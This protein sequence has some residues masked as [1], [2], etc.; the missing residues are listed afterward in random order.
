MKYFIICF[1]KNMCIVNW[2]LGCVYMHSHLSHRVQLVS[3]LSG[4]VA[5]MTGTII[6]LTSNVAMLLIWTWP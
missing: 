4:S 2:N 1:S 6:P 3:L 5:K